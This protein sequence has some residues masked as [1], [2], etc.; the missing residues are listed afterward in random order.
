MKARTPKCRRCKSTD[1]SATSSQQF[2]VIDRKRQQVAD[3]V[4]N[5]CGH[6]WW[7]VNPVIRALARQA[8]T[9][10]KPVAASSTF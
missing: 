5:E 2:R 6:T 3:A 8:D 10:R 9:A 7:S 4:C 1:I